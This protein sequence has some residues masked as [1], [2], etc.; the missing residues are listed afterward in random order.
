MHLVRQL[1]E[2]VALRAGL[3]HLEEIMA[4]RDVAFSEDETDEELLNVAQRSALACRRL[5]ARLCSGNI[6]NSALKTVAQQ[7]VAL[8]SLDLGTNQGVGTV[9]LTDTALVTIAQNCTVLTKLF[10]TDCDWVT[11]KGVV[12]IAEGCPVLTRLSLRKSFKVGDSAFA[13][14]G[15]H[16]HLLVF[17]ML[18][19]TQLGD[20]GVRA[21]VVGCPGLRTLFACGTKVTEECIQPLSELKRLTS[22]WLKR[23]SIPPQGAG[24]TELCR[25]RPRLD[26]RIE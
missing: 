9:K 2:I 18:N 23:N 14:L 24:A 13:A 26:L 5:D 1:S 12:A 8:D 20:D 21:L 4:H 15:Q 3:P 16:C 11:D 22:C 25:R 6:S 7:C 19:D 17:L 10:L